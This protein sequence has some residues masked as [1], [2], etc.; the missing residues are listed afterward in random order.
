M[1]D[2]GIEHLINAVSVCGQPQQL[3]QVLQQTLPA[4]IFQNLI[5]GLPTMV[6]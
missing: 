6:S 4:R 3:L 2:E 1:E 5:T